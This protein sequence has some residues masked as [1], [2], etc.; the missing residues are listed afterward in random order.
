[1]LMD[2]FTA[3]RKTDVV[4]E[5]SENLLSDILVLERVDEIRM[6]V[7]RLLFVKSKEWTESSHSLTKWKTEHVQTDQ[8]M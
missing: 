3:N 5:K 8:G 4:E 2:Q 6:Q 7:E 1:M